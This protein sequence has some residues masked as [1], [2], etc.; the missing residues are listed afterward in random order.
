MQE[1]LTRHMG[2]PFVPEPMELATARILC[3]DLITTCEGCGEQM[4][5]GTE[6]DGY[7]DYYCHEE[8]TQ[9]A[10]LV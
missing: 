10:P 9:R 5:M 4:V 2:E 3:P 7:P 1:L 8:C 6:L